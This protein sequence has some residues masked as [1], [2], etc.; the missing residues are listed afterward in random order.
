MVSN[1]KPTP[2]SPSG[3]GCIPGRRERVSTTDLRPWPAVGGI[4]CSGLAVAVACGVRDGEGPEDSAL[5]PM[6]AATSMSPLASMG[7]LPSAGLVCCLLSFVG[8]GDRGG[9]F[10]EG[11]RCACCCCLLPWSTPACSSA[12][13]NICFAACCSAKD[14][15]CMKCCP[16][17]RYPATILSWSA[18]RRACSSWLLS[19]S[20]RW[21]LVSPPWGSGDFGGICCGCM[22]C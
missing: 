12:F 17:F 14:L 6:N 2:T 10:G 3:P 5:N 16:R 19:R 4:S 1:E 8:V 9:R 15:P 18:F 13:S 11:E 7:S 20:N 21:S 22:R